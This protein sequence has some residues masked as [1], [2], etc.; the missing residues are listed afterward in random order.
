MKN[1]GLN[2]G[3]EMVIAIMLTMTMIPI[4]FTL[5]GCFFGQSELFNGIGMAAAAIAVTFMLRSKGIDIKDS[6]KPKQFELKNTVFM[7]LLIFG[8]TELIKL[9]SGLFLSHFT[10]IEKQ[11]PIEF[12]FTNFI[13]LLIIIPVFYELIFRVG[14]I[15]AFSS[16]AC[17]NKSIRFA[18]FAAALCEAPF[19]SPDNQQLPAM[20]FTAVMLSIVY[21]STGNILNTISIHVVLNVTRFI[22]FE[23]YSYINGFAIPSVPHIIACAVMAA[24][25][26]IY[27]FGYFRPRYIKKTYAPDI[28]IISL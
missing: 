21:I 6:V 14:I 4:G 19:Y 20:L 8:I 3:T 22:P 17:M 7:S 10:S 24:V 28:N 25:G 26:M 16:E 5:I 2:K 1:K 11:P 12:G 13:I 9:M 18:V 23:S 15:K 27:F